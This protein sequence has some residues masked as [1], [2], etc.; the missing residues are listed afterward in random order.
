MVNLIRPRKR[1]LLLDRAM[2]KNS[3]EYAMNSAGKKNGIGQTTLLE[4]VSAAA[5]HS[6]D[7]RE[8]ARLVGQLINRHRFVVSSL[9][10]IGGQ[11]AD[12]S[13]LH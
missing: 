2:L 9:P 13:V 1:T 4:L 10:L 5:E 8:V 7:D 3:E 12:E 6:T 11:P